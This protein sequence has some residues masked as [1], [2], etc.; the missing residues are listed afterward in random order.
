VRGALR[1]YPLKVVVPPYCQ[2][3]R[4]RLFRVLRSSRLVAP[5]RM[6]FVLRAMPIMIGSEDAGLEVAREYLASDV[7]DKI[8]NHQAI[9]TP[10]ETF[11]LLWEQLRLDLD[12]HYG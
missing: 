12:T 10:E 6:R 11:E 1:Q 3:R 7:R 4:G 8:V 9:P 5:D 2:S